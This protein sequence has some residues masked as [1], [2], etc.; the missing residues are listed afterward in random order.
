M[1]VVILLNLFEVFMDLI[2]LFGLIVDVVLEISYDFFNLG[3]VD[4]YCEYIDMLVLKSVFWDYEE[5]LFNDGCMGIVVFNLFI[6]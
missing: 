3:Y 1:V 2:E 4:F 6:F 5:F